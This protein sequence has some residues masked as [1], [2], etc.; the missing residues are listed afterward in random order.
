MGKTL[1]FLDPLFSNEKT[2]AEKNILKEEIINECWKYLDRDPEL[3]LDNFIIYVT[4]EQTYIVPPTG[5]SRVKLLEYMISFFEAR[6]E[7]EKCAH[8]V[9]IKEKILGN[10]KKF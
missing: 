2:P 1:D 5:T 10:I 7:F 9:K 8:L 4:K 3:I 6:E